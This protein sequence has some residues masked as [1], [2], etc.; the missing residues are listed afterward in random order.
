MQLE[1][2]KHAREKMVIYGITK[3]QVKRT[4]QQGAKFEQTDGF[5]VKYSYI[6]AAYKKRGDFYK[7]KT[8]YVD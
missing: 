5:L 7:I 4:I 8:V 2:T 3:E 6:R 1:I